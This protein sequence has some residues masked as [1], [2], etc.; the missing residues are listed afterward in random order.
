[1]TP[2]LMERTAGQR[3]FD[4]LVAIFERAASTAPDARP[5]A[6]VVNLIMDVESWEAWLARTV[7]G[8]PDAPLPDV[9][10]ER[11]RC[12]TVDGM[13]V[14]P[15]DAIAASLAGHVRRVVMDRAGSQATP[16]HRLS[17]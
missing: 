3:R 7:G 12:E 13:Q 5:P 8:Q 14:D 16:V 10:V 17:P 6:P 15:A 4:A 9:D 1:M 11:R 2:A